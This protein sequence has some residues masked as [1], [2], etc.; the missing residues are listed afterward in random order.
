MR[1]SERLIEGLR[2]W[3]QRR[4]GTDVNEILTFN[5]ILALFCFSLFYLLIFVLFLYFAVFI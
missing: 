4:I 1:A 3:P 5:K 2:G